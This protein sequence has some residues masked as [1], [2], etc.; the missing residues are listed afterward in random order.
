MAY[1]QLLPLCLLQWQTLPTPFQC[2]EICRSWWVWKN[3]QLVKQFSHS[4]VCTCTACALSCKISVEIFSRQNVVVMGSVMNC[5][6]DTHLQRN[7]LCKRIAALSLLDQPP[8]CRVA[9]PPTNENDHHITQP[10]S[11]DIHPRMIFHAHRRS[12]MKQTRSSVSRL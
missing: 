10:T 5:Q 9:E 3:L 6:V 11:G 8:L 1:H 2:Q 12:G 4:S 7:A